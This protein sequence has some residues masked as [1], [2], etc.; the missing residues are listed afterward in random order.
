MRVER[1]ESMRRALDTL[2]SAALWASALCLV[3][4][5]AMVGAQL[6]GR[7]VDGWPSPPPST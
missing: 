5:A 1:I 4:I 3:A 7:I 6:A 2:Y